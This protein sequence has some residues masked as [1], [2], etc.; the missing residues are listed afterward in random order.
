MIKFIRITK[1]QNDKLTEMVK[2][3]FLRK[4]YIHSFRK[5]SLYFINN[6]IEISCMNIPITDY[7]IWELPYLQYK[8]GKYFEEIHWYE[9]CIEYLLPKLKRSYCDYI[10]QKNERNKI[11]II[12][13]CFEIFK[14]NI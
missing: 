9:F 6:D 10:Q 5:S 13:Y 7:N 12:D 2:K 8:V 14:R 1:E 4:I 3:L 11:H